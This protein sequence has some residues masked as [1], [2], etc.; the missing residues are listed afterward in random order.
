MKAWC[1]PSFDWKTSQLA[2]GEIPSEPLAALME[3][4]RGKQPT[5]YLSIRFFL[6]VPSV[7]IS[8]KELS[9]DRAACPGGN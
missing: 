7:K 3:I 9:A 8:G 5:G 4:M 2:I 1:S 6:S